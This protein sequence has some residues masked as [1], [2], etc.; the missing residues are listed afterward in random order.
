MTATPSASIEATS[1]SA[2]EQRGNIARLTVA[3]ALSGA[4]AV[5]VYATGAIIG[6]MFAPSE[7]LATLLVSIFVVGMAACILPVGAIARRHGRRAAFLVGTGGGVLA[8]LFGALAVLWGSFWL[9]CLA[10]AWGGL[11]FWLYR[12]VGLS[13]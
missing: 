9:F 1:A 12:C 5:V 2:R 8:G 13:A 10:L 4:N 3:Q 11:E 6:H 7:A